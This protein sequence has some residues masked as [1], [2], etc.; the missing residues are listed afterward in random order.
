MADRKW[1]KAKDIFIDALRQT[2]EKRP[3]YLDEVCDDEEMRREVE[4]F[5]YSF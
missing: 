3:H 5:V 1:Q 4:V 2:P